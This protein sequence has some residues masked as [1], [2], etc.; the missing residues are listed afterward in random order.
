LRSARIKPSPLKA[1]AVGSSPCHGARMERF[2][3]A[4]ASAALAHA[5]VLA[6]VSRLSVSMPP[7]SKLREVEVSIEP[8]PFSVAPPSQSSLAGREMTGTEAIGDSTETA[9]RSAPPYGS[10]AGITGV[11]PSPAAPEASASARGDSWSLTGLVPGAI[12]AWLPQADGVGLAANIAR[13]GTIPNEPPGSAPR[14]AEGPPPGAA[15]VSST[16]GL[17]EG[18]HAHDVELGLAA[19][20]P[21]VGAAEQATRESRAPVDGFAL[22]RADFDAGGKI[23]NVRVLDASSESEAWREVASAIAEA[24][25]SK[26]VHVPPGSRGVIVTLRVES[27]W[28]NADGSLPGGPAVCVLG[29]PCDPNPRRK[30]IVIGPGVIAGDLIPTTKDVASRQ[31]HARIV[32]ETVF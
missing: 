23:Q 32:G 27:A 13:Y 9:E 28:L 24:L 17:R 4:F 21:I 16:G 22:F 19:T 14:S 7:A 6:A 20:G 25:R 12:D 2:G 5:I 18:L 15:P 30:R 8:S 3:R 11:R 26:P 1:L 31:V 10:R 29:L